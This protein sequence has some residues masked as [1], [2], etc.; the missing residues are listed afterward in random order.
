[1]RKWWEAGG[2]CIMRSFIACFTKYYWNDELKE[3]EVGRACSTCGRY[4]KY[5]QNFGQKS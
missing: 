3:D 1:V 5:I 4:V 2:D